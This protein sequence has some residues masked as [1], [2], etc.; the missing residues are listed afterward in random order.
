LA[1][2]V[3]T[4]LGLFQEL[5]ERDEFLPIYL[6]ETWDIVRLAVFLLPSFF[7][8]V[9]PVTF[10]FGILLA[11]GHLAETNQITAMKAAGIPLKRIIL[12][13]LGMAVVLT[14]VSFFVQD[15]L[16]PWGLARADKLLFDDFPRRATLD[17]LQPGVMHEF[18]DWHVYI[19]ESDRETGTLYNIDLVIPEPNGVLLLHAKKARLMDTPD[20]NYIGMPRAYILRSQGNG[21]F[22]PSVAGRGEEDPF[23][24]RLPVLQARTAPNERRLM[25]IGSLIKHEQEAAVRYKDSPVETNKEE[26]RK[27]R[28]EIGGRLMSPLMCLAVALVGAPLGARARRGGRSYS[29]AIGVGICLVYYLLAVTLEPRALRG[30][31]TVLLNHGLPSLVLGLVGLVFLWRVDRI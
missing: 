17:M 29:F 31:D 13:I 23:M 7:Q 11:F 3:L 27:T 9:I 1:I 12:P 22:A 2:L 18:G 5:K 28:A 24:R 6:I 10:L 15:R 26:L 25:S 8:V 4:F 20:G 30:L 14:A 16:Q 21:D 19:G